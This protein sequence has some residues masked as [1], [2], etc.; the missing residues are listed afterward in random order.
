MLSALGTSA[1][2]SDGTDSLEIYAKLLDPQEIV[3]EYGPG[4]EL[5]D[6]SAKVRSSAIS[7][8]AD[9]YGSLRGLTLSID[10]SDYSVR[11]AE[12]RRSGFTILTLEDA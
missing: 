7:D 11:D 10:G 5:T 3:S 6:P 4:V 9:S 2:I 12:A 1:T 8:L